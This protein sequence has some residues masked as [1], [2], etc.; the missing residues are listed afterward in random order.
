MKTGSTSGPRL[1]LKNVES[2]RPYR[3]YHVR[4][5]EMTDVSLEQ[6][7]RNRTWQNRTLTINLRA[8]E[9][10]SNAGSIPTSTEQNN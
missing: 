5:V 1:Q 6:G 9:I 4:Y 7:G 3:A 2:C 8:P 10:E